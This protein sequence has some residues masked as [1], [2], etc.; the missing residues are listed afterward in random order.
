MTKKS[1]ISYR[2]E[3]KRGDAIVNSSLT[4]SKSLLIN[5]TAAVAE[6]VVRRARECHCTSTG[7][8][9]SVAFRR[10][11]KSAQVTRVDRVESLWTYLRRDLL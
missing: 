10:G 2:M 7:W 11:S 8:R 6:I 3:I 1:A 5:T 4:V 9:K